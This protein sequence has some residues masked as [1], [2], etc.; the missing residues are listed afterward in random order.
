M[1]KTEI[2]EYLINKGDILET[3]AGKVKQS[4]F[5]STNSRGNIYIKDIEDSEK[6]KYSDWLLAVQRFLKEYYLKE[7]EE[8]KKTISYFRS[9]GFIKSNHL[10][11]TGTLKA[12]RLVEGDLKI[13]KDDASTDINTQTGEGVLNLITEIIQDEITGKEFKELNAIWKKFEAKPEE[14][15][16]S[17][18]GKFE[19]LGSGVL[20]NILVNVMNNLKTTLK[21][22]P[23]K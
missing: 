17:L 23:A 16:D 20:A 19:G 11:I 5:T 15:R 3:I 2:L 22:E 12:I 13:T 7:S 21:N 8:T 10:K 9:E 1:D 18:V 4:A 6:Y 14:T